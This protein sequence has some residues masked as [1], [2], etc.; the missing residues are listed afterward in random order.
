MG[1]AVAQLNLPGQEQSPREEGTRAQL[2]LMH[3]PSGSNVLTLMDSVQAE[4]YEEEST[5]YSLA[6]SG[7]KKRANTRTSLRGSG[8]LTQIKARLV[9]ERQSDMDR[10]GGLAQI[11]ISSSNERRRQ[12]VRQFSARC[13]ARIESALCKSSEK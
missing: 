9:L 4:I 5:V 8:R 2:Q 10:K 12:K 3:S 1:I 11:R 6:A 7:A 13:K